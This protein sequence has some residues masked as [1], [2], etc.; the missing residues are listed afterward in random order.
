MGTFMAE[1][2]PPDPAIAE[3]PASDRL[4]TWGEIAAHLNREIRTVQ[5]WEK[6][7]G[8]PVRR[9]GGGTEKLSRVYA[10]KSE[11]DA[12]WREHEV[13]RNAPEHHDEASGSHPAVVVPPPSPAG[14]ET[15]E[16]PHGSRVV[17]RLLQG[18][19]LIAATVL[20]TF[21]IPKIVDRIWP[22]K[23]V[24]AIP[25]F[26]NLGEKADDYIAAG[27][28]EEMIARLGQLHPDLMSVLPVNTGV[29]SGRASGRAT[30]VLRGTVRR[31][32]DQVAV[33][34]QLL[35][36]SN[37]T[38]VWGN[39]YER[40]VKDL[41]RVQT[42]VTEAIAS[43]VFKKLPHPATPARE[44]NRD[45]YLSY[46]EGRYFWSQRTAE[47]IEKAVALFEKSIG[48]DPTYAPAYAG[49]AD[50]YELLGSAPYTAMPPREAFPKAEVAARKALE[51]DES[52]AE[53]HVSLGYAYLAYEWK[54]ADADREFR[55]ALDLRPSY[56]TGHQY[57]G[58]A[59]TAAGKLQE[60]IEERKKAV[61]LDPVSPLMASALGEA[62]YQARQFDQTIEQNQ[63][64][65]EL[66]SRYA[67]ALVNIGRAYQQKGLHPQAQAAFQKILAVV[68]DDPAVL[69][70]L[71]H[72]Y[73][74]SGQ[75]D[76]A[77]RV[78]AK[79]K[80]RAAQRYVPA[81]YIAL[82]YTGLGDRNEA[83]HWMEA[84]V[85]E[86][87]EYLVY[88]GSDPLADPLRGDPRFL[89]LMKQVGIT[90]K[91]PLGPSASLVPAGHA[92][93]S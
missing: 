21:F 28:T 22:S 16:R 64:A 46:L 30:Y 87:T 10:L 50:C 47:S 85:N 12:W 68:P 8:L 18:A 7:M 2:R 74:V 38:V 76:E 49:L 11:L 9:L 5:R 69:A 40:D 80:S 58:Y 31:F 53:A 56:A 24:I 41:L 14:Q 63:R 59:L 62:Y 25:P 55:R 88:L 1:D 70:L 91:V 72:E 75:R 19:V 17:G 43:E 78:L 20:L 61:D 23:V 84:A 15:D 66:D 45:A 32:N 71:G 51:L 57:Y 26:R 3:R 13:L 35:E 82:I 81:I 83:F 60:A 34:A 33:T 36:T 52:L 29:G 48:K 92:N 27:L 90:G 77:M 37:Q 89:D 65:L 4:E 42:E 93:R 54:F 6:G 67:I 86:R 44:V 73:A 79:L 39:S